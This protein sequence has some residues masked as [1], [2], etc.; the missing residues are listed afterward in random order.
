MLIKLARHAQARLQ[1]H[2]FFLKPD[3]VPIEGP[4]SLHRS[5]ALLPLQRAPTL[6]STLATVGSTPSQVKPGR[7]RA[8]NSS[9]AGLLR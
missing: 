7:R 6:E 4:C 1:A 2:H 3:D 8:P 9:F 5:V